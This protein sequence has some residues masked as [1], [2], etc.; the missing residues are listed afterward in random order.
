MT[1]GLDGV[2]QRGFYISVW[3]ARNF[4]LRG[5]A[6]DQLIINAWGFQASANGLAAIAALTLIALFVMR[7]R[8]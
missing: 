4:S 1:Q 7:L 5:A 2:T 8:R 6:M 3:F